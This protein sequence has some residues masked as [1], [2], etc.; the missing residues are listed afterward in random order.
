MYMQCVVLGHEYTPVAIV[1]T[2]KE[3]EVIFKGYSQ[4]YK[5][6]REW[7][8]GY[9][10]LCTQLR[11]CQLMERVLWLYQR[12]AV[13]LERCLHVRHILS[14]ANTVLC[15]TYVLQLHALACL[16]TY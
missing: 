8:V 12:K 1:S 15:E 14:T 2:A 4:L 9:L 6:K 11:C 3:P 10:S 16:W 7:E 13:S 5:R